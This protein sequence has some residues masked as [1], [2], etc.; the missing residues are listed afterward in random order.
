MRQ[1]FDV[2]DLSRQEYCQRW[3]LKRNKFDDSLDTMW[4][5]ICRLDIVFITKELDWQ[6]KL[7][8]TFTRNCNMC[9]ANLQWMQGNAFYFQVIFIYPIK[10]YRFTIYPY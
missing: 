2:D 4:L 7:L 9:S 3:L 1:T 8:T 10:Q 5:E 6:W